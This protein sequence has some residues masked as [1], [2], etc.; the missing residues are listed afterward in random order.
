MKIN[1][2]QIFKTHKSDRKMDLFKNE[3]NSVEIK[4]NFMDYFG[5]FNKS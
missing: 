1:L 4:F 3:L 2:N 5:K